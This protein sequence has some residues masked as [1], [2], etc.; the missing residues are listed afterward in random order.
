MEQILKKRKTESISDKSLF[1]D[2]FS[3]RDIFVNIIGTLANDKF[4][5]TKLRKEKNNLY[6][7][8]NI[9]LILFGYSEIR[10]NN[11]NYND[12]INLKIIHCKYLC[13]NNERSNLKFPYYKEYIFFM[14]ESTIN[15]IIYSVLF[16]SPAKI[17][18]NLV[19]CFDT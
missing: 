4:E 8:A 19:T 15:F 18:T 1:L 12:V 2:V 3:R 11:L 10:E 14:N 9:L 6:T 13:Y 16:L 7:P 5:K 17:M